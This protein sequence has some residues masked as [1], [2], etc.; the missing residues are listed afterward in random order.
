[1]PRSLHAPRGTRSSRRRQ[2]LLRRVARHGVPRGARHAALAGP[3][4]P[5][6]AN[7][8]STVSVGTTASRAA[9]AAMAARRPPATT[10]VRPMKSP[11]SSLYPTTH[12][13]ATNHLPGEPAGRGGRG[14]CRGRRREEAGGEEGQ[15]EATEGEQEE[16]RRGRR[17]RWRWRWRWRR[18]QGTG[19]GRRGAGAG[20]GSGGAA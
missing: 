10:S 20:A 19:V 14:A 16:G 12:V 6:L 13:G 9:A 8:A 17:W 7:A 18:G 1:M 11:L 15:G 2:P 3:W 5:S 4:Q